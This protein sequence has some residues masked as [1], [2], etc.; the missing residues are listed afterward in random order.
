MQ[1]KGRWSGEW[2]GLGRHYPA[3]LVS[4]PGSV[5][6]R[7]CSPHD[8]FPLFLVR[9]DRRECFDLASVSSVVSA[10]PDTGVALVFLF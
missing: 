3:F 10:I 5:T 4:T 7:V 6:R 2:R 1:R 9:R 8:G